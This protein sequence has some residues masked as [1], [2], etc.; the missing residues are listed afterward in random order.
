[1]VVASS[2]CVCSCLFPDQSGSPLRS[3]SVRRIAQRN[4]VAMFVKHSADRSQPVRRSCPRCGH[5]PLSMG[6]LGLRS[7]VRVRSPAYWA[8]WADCL[9]MMQARH[10]RVVAEILAE[11]GD[12]SASPCLEE[13]RSAA[14]DLFGVMGF[15]PPSWHA[16]VNGARPPHDGEHEPGCFERGW[17]HE[18][19]SR[20]E[21]QHREVNLFPRLSE[22]GRALVRSQAGPSSGLALSTCPTCRITSLDSHL[23]RVLLLRRLQLPLPLCVLVGVAAHLNRAA[24]ARAGVLGRRGC[25]VESVAARILSGSW[26]AGCAQRLRA[27]P[28]SGCVQRGRRQEIGSGGGWVAPFRRS[29]IGSGHHPGER[30]SG[31]WVWKNRGSAKGRSCVGSSKTCRK[32]ALP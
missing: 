18:A 22:A 13:A 19:S 30:S 23:F 28:R 15:E 8:S 21:R 14:W 5:L 11:L 9:P 26:R 2:L 3:C 4:I 17:Q 27:R 16:V 31:R 1:M 12:R 29:P 25:A 6:G 32:T 24:C 20:V 10:P 7:A